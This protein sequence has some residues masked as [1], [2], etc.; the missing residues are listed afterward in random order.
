[1][2]DQLQQGPFTIYIQANHR[3]WL[4]YT[5]GI[6]SSKDCTYTRLDHAVTVVGLGKEVTTYTTKTPNK[7]RNKCK[8]QRNG[9][10]KAGWNQ[11]RRRNGRIVCCKRKLIEEGETTTVTVDQ[12]YWLVQN[13]WGT[14]WGDNGFIKLAVED[15]VGVLG[16]N[17]YAES[18]EVQTVV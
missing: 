6:L 15:G 9:Q 12:E 5:G 13:S 1:M 11:K 7:Y 3:C 16:M 17:G 18:I 8:R 10:C 14:W 4:D 2:K